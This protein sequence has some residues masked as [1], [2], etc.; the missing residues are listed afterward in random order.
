M[1]NLQA[2]VSN[3]QRNKDQIQRGSEFS[4]PTL[5]INNIFSQGESSIQQLYRPQ[6]QV[7]PHY[8]GIGNPFYNPFSS[9][10]KNIGGELKQQ[11]NPIFGMLGSQEQE[12]PIMKNTHYGPNSVLNSEDHHSE[13]EH[14]FVLNMAKGATNMNA[15]FQQ[16]QGSNSCVMENCDVYF[17]LNVDYVFQSLG[18]L[19]ANL[20]NE[21]DS[22]FDQVY[23][24]DQV[25]VST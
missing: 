14:N 9:A 2:N 5:N 18:P 16:Y 10:Q 21:Q 1:P 19:G 12:N 15:N 23:S 7:Q 11:H 4:L 22:E 13:K 25:S 24:D 3:Q 20:P 6:L 8:L 17:S